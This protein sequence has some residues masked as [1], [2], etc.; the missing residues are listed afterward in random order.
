MFTCLHRCDF[1]LMLCLQVL[2]WDACWYWDRAANDGSLDR[3]ANYGW[4]EWTINNDA[5]MVKKKEWK[6][7]HVLILHS[8]MLSTS[9]RWTWRGKKGT[10]RFV[11]TSR[12][13][14]A[15]TCSRSTLNTHYLLLLDTPIPGL[16][17]ILFWL[18]ACFT[19]DLVIVFPAYR[20]NILL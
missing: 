11:W 20:K 1:V 15:T 17:Y 2:W 19:I 5:I 18:H 16:H 6:E 3:I 10:T 8:N 7:L 9:R 12:R 4:L 14:K 13:L